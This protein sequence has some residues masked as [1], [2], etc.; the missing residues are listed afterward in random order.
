MITKKLNFVYS[1]LT[2]ENY[3]QL[4]QLAITLFQTEYASDLKIQNSI[5]HLI[6]AIYAFFPPS[7]ETYSQFDSNQLAKILSIYIEYSDILKNIPESHEV[8]SSKQEIFLNTLNQCEPSPVFVELLQKTFL[9]YSPDNLEILTNFLPKVQASAENPESRAPLAGLFEEM[10]KIESLNLEPEQIEMFWQIITFYFNFCEQI[11]Q[12]ES[13]SDLVFGLASFIWGEI[14]DYQ[15]EE[16]EIPIENQI[17]LF[18]YFNQSLTIFANNLEEFYNLITIGANKYHNLISI[19]KDE[20][21]GVITNFLDILIEVGDNDSDILTPEFAQAFFDLTNFEDEIFSM[22]GEPLIEYYINK[23]ESPSNTLYFAVASSKYHIKSRCA[24]PFSEALTSIEPPDCLVYFIENCSGF[25]PQGAQMYAPVLFETFQNDPTIDNMRI[26]RK[27]IVEFPE[28]F[29]QNQNEYVKTMLDWLPEVDAPVTGKLI[30]G[31]LSLCTK[32]SLSEE[33]LQGLLS[34]MLDVIQSSAETIVGDGTPEEMK[35]F[36]TYCSDL[37]FPS[38]MET[39]PNEHTYIPPPEPVV[40]FCRAA[41]ERLTQVTSPLWSAED[42]DIQMCLCEFLV[43]TLRSNWIQDNDISTIGEWLSGILQTHPVAGHIFLLEKIWKHKSVQTDPII[44]ALNTFPSNEESPGLQIMTMHLFSLL[45]RHWPEFYQRINLE[46]IIPPLSS[47]NERVV[48]R[49]LDLANKVVQT[50]GSPD[51][52][53]AILPIIRD[54]IFTKYNQQIRPKALNVILSI[55]Q[56]HVPPEETASCLLEAIPFR[57]EHTERL[58]QILSEATAISSEKLQEIQDA[59]NAMNVEITIIIN[60]MEQ[61]QQ[62]Q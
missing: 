22:Y 41:F 32:L 9:Y 10:T 39:K 38:P 28:F 27:L 6:A 30:N 31:I 40:D 36:V 11:I 54:C 29:I 48:D 12:D 62:Q 17:E 7:F 58:Q 43:K 56:L 50:V 8:F 13:V 14:M 21:W 1:S 26:I 49:A 55:A 35:N 16:L 45:T 57:D 53:Q 60:Q 42:D 37:M 51:F 23:L 5:C 25:V 20:F 61:L 3:T 46:G 19:G 59:I 47:D 24:I 34:G 52:S 44:D 4:Y 15:I 18:T 33:D 2:E